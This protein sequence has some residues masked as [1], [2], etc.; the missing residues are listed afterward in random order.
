MIRA[1]TTQDP[2]QAILA[3]INQKLERLGRADDDLWDADNI[4]DYMKLSKKSVFN[5]IVNDMT[6]PKSV[7]LVTG[8]R[9]WIAKEVKAWTLKRRPIK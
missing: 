9:R 3:E 1:Q 7:P 6:F 5:N 8:G 2:I 4:A